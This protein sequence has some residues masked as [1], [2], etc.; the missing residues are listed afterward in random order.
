MFYYYWH[1]FCVL[2]VY[3]WRKTRKNVDC[4]LEYQPKIRLAKVSV[5][6]SKRKDL[7]CSA[8]SIIKIETIIDIGCGTGLSTEV[9]TLFANKVIGVEPSID[10]LNKAK[11]KENEKMKFI[12]GYGNKTGLEDESVDIVI[13][14]KR[15]IGWSQKQH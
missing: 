14:S 1:F 4:I 13:C 15:F 12:Q 5:C 7:R 10:M 11:T 2:G 9:C 8:S 6:Q 3:E